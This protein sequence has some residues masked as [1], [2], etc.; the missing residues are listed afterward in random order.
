MEEAVATKTVGSI[1]SVRD[2]KKLYSVVCDG[3][4]DFKMFSTPE[5]AA[6]WNR[7]LQHS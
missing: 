5:E 1:G 3:V 6:E 7:E 2:T 4:Q